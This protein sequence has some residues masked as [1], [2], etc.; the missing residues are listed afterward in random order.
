MRFC[1]TWACCSRPMRPR[2]PL[3]KLALPLPKVLDSARG[4]WLGVLAM[5]ISLPPCSTQERSILRWLSGQWLL[6][7]GGRTQTTSGYSATF[8]ASGRL[9]GLACSKVMPKPRPSRAFFAASA[10]ETST[11]RRADFRGWVN[12]PVGCWV[13]RV[14]AQPALPSAGSGPCR[15]PPTVKVRL[16]AARPAVPARP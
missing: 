7:S 5:S 15:C 12:S 2:S 11:T 10:S 6:Q 3:T 14:L 4:C 16:Y 8:P 9:S 13:G 1:R